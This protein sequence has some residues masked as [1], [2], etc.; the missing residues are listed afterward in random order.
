[1][2]CAWGGFAGYGV[3]MITSYIVGQKYYPLNYPLKDITLY[4]ILAA[5]AFVAMT[6]LHEKLSMWLSIAINTL[7]ILAFIALIIKRDLP[8]S[9]LPIIGKKFKKK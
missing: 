4:T 2:A 6:L 3:A 1:M 8:L 9:K 7:L 5:I